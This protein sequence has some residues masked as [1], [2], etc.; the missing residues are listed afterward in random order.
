[1]DGGEEGAEEQELDVLSG[2]VAVRGEFDEH[3]VASFS[4]SRLM[5]QAAE[6]DMLLLDDDTSL[7]EMRRSRGVS[8][9]G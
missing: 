8:M 6:G 5:L 9:S 7:L 1:V 3:Y 4:R 2:A